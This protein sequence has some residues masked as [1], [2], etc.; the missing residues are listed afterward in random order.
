[1]LKNKMLYLF[2]LLIIAA[3]SYWNRN[4]I[5]NLYYLSYFRPT[6]YLN[7]KY[8]RNLN[9]RLFKPKTF[10]GKKYPLLL[11][12]HPSG[13]EGSDNKK[14]ISSLVFEWA[15][16][17]SQSKYPCYIFA[18]QCPQ[19][20]EWVNK[21]PMT[22]PFTHY[23]QDDYSEGEEMKMIVEAI[24]QLVRTYPI[25]PSRIYAIGFSMGATGC[26]DILTRHPDLFAASI[27]A[28]GVS[29]TSKAFKLA[30]VPIWAFSGE[31]DKV[32]PPEL[33]KTMVETIN[34]Y[35]GN[36]KITMFKGEGHSIGNLSFKYPGVKKWLFSQKKQIPESY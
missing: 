25:D 11:Y 10:Q 6:V 21:G 15:K 36:A 16:N 20:F 24:K 33:N 31:N 7:D 23:N 18:P 4:K 30:N 12:L 29:D 8:E 35:G 9:F 22:I 19:G 1:M 28:S 2:L 27:I 26:W 32:A 3:F 5:R 14:Q 34:H 13:E 17:E